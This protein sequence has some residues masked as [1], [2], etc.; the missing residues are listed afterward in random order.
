MAHGG[1]SNTGAPL[2]AA[3]VIE[4]FCAASGSVPLLAVRVPLN[5]PDAVGV[6]EITPELR[7]IVNPDGRLAAENVTGAQLAAVTV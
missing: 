6:P 5:E 3:M 4:K 1:E 2:T 7:L